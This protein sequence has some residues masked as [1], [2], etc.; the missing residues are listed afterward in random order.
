MRKQQYVDFFDAHHRLRVTMET[1]RGR[2]RA[3]AAQL[4]YLDKESWV[5]IARFD[6]AGGKAHLDRNRIVAHEPV[7]L[8]SEPGK[9]LEVAIDIL[10]KARGNILK[11]TK[12]LR[13]K[14]WNV[15]A[16]EI[17]EQDA[18]LL[19]YVKEAG[20]A[21]MGN[22]DLLEALP[23][24]FT[25]VALPQDDPELAHYALSLLKDAE[26]PLIYALVSKSKVT[27]LLPGGP[28]QEP[29]VAA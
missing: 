7:A 3:W 25:L 26:Q 15:V 28:V 2:M 17:S 29:L 20:A 5:W 18:R 1:R 8:P 14:G 6:T 27:F 13:P 19:D 21:L 12:R 9:A 16:T 23:E 4:E 11:P 24:D 10:I 22:L